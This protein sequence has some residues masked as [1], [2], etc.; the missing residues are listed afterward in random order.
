MNW[1]ELLAQSSS[2]VLHETNVVAADF[3]ALD[4]EVGIG[5]RDLCAFAK[6]A[7]FHFSLVSVSARLAASWHPVEQALFQKVRIS[8]SPI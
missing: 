8:D 5:F 4:L 1:T 3:N 6:L 7:H 2:M